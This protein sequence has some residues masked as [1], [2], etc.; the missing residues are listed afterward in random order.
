MGT[1]YSISS[2]KN[3]L[4]YTS[5]S[6][7]CL[8]TAV[9]TEITKPLILCNDYSSSLSSAVYHDIIYFIYQNTEGDLIFRNVLDSTILFH[10]SAKDALHYFSPQLLACEKDLIL[11]YLVENPLSGEYILKYTHPLDTP[12]VSQDIDTYP[13][14]P[15]IQCITLHKTFLLICNSPDEDYFYIKK[16][17]C[18]QS[19]L[20][21]TTEELENENNQKENQIAKIEQELLSINTLLTQKEQEV[22]E[23][24]KT[25]ESAKQQYDNLMNTAYRYKEEAEKWYTKYYSRK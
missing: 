13:L 1:I 9:G 5:G 6:S 15:K 19:F 20:L 17:N 11:L 4:L 10:L 7:I 2:D 25:I 8:R 23:K 18:F 12:N 21:K 22:L 24:V 14:L 3:L 16:S